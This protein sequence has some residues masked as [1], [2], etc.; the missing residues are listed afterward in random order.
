MRNMVHS[1]TAYYLTARSFGLLTALDLSNIGMAGSNPA[2]R[3]DIV[4]H[5][6]VETSVYPNFLSKRN[7]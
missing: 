3:M 2:L 6:T 4:S 7:V 1:F 5:F